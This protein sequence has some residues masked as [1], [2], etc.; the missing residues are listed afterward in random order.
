[1]RKQHVATGFLVYF[2]ARFLGYLIARRA[3]I[4]FEPRINAGF[5]EAD[6]NPES[7]AD[8]NL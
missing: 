5:Y 4:R 8:T 2:L 7:N 1:M 6:F 3:L